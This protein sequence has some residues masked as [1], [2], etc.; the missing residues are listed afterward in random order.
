MNI[1][2]HRLTA[3]VVYNSSANSS[4]YG[5]EK[6]TLSFVG[7][8]TIENSSTVVNWSSGVI[9]SPNYPQGMEFRLSAYC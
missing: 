8:Y 5:A 1:T 2:T 4:S 6:Y 9:S 3:N 7:G